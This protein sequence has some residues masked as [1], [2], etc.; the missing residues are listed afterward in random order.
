MIVE[1]AKV[2]LDHAY[3]KGYGEMYIVDENGNNVDFSTMKLVDDN[4]NVVDN[5]L[6]ADDEPSVQ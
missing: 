6:I 2:Y 4:G 3:D 1:V 5:M